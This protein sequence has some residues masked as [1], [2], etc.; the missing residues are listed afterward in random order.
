VAAASYSSSLLCYL[1][2]APL[3][4]L[5]ASVPAISC[6]SSTVLL[7]EQRGH[8]ATLHGVALAQAV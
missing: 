1:A 4:S 2:Q 6:C 3:A 7:N 8:S 5:S